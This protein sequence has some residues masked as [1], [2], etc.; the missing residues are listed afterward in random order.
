M[1]I[2]GEAARLELG[3]GVADFVV[4]DPPYYDSVQYGDLAQF[5]E[6]WLRYYLP[7]EELWSFCPGESRVTTD[8]NW[9]S[10][11][12][13]MTAIMSECRRVIRKP[14]GRIVLTFHHWRA[15]AWAALTIAMAEAD[16]RLVNRY[17]VHSENRQSVHIANLRSLTD[18]CILVLSAREDE[19]GVEWMEPG[20]ISTRT[21]KSFLA[22][23]GS[24]LGWML[25]NELS[26][27]S[28][29]ERWR[30]LLG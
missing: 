12:S 16:L 28:V 30:R 2:R 7:N 27:E 26:P 17:V 15:S 5:F 18:D 29:Y 9:R 6:V 14:G 24:A 1:S 23:C 3:D 11:A 25:E 20:S 4:T 22:A 8:G 10:F 13:D 21:S 19:A